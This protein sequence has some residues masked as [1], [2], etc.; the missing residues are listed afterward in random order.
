MILEK[1][2]RFSDA[3]FRRVAKSEAS[4]RICRSEKRSS[5]KVG[6]APSRIYIW[7]LRWQEQGVF[8]CAKKAFFQVFLN[9][10]VSDIG[11][12]L[13]LWGT[14]ELAWYGL[15]VGR[16]DTISLIRILS[17][18][19][20]LH[21][22]RSC[23]SC[24]RKSRILRWFL[25]DFCGLSEDAF[26][27]TRGRR[28][29][30]LWWIFFGLLFGVLGIVTSPM[31]ATVGIASAILLVLLFAVP[32]LSLFLLMFALPFLNLFPHPTLVLIAVVFV[33]GLACLGKLVSG[34]RQV[35][36]G[37]TDG[38]VLWLGVLYALSGAVSYGSPRDGFLRAF[39]LLTG[40]F[41]ARI[42]LFQTKWRRRGV[43]ALS[44]A[45]LICAVIGIVEY[46]T[47]NAP[48]G[49]VDKSRFEDIGGRV[50]GVFNNPNLFAIFLL[51]TTLLPLSVCFKK[52]GTAT[53]WLCFFSFF[54]GSVCLVLTWSRGAWL[55]WIISV[56]LL[57]MLGSRRSFSLLLLG[58]AF[59]VCAIS[60]LP[61]SMIS[62]FQSIGN[63][64]DTSIHYRLN[65]WKGVL[66]MIGS[67]PW[68]IGCGEEAFH[69]VFS[70]YAVSGTE[71]V[72]HPHQML[73]EAIS[74]LGVVGFLFFLLIIWRLL[75]RFLRF[76]YAMPQGRDRGEGIAIFCALAGGMVMGMFDSLWYH[77]GLFWLFWVFCGMCENLR[78]EVTK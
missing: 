11:T 68:G 72:M 56:F 33:C 15:L 40:W 34:K 8:F 61:S 60:F 65:T 10:R 4:K 67:H 7:M 25:F 30:R 45:S 48:L 53:K 70:A 19:V 57:L 46:V 1:L 17:A 49:W 42:L 54:A 73:L 13:V 51:L 2:D 66:R 76:C 24:I 71:G 6:G 74:E 55:G 28:T 52:D 18:S 39:L 9:S 58:G 50:C 29:S 16:F 35:E 26:R 41:L 23:G 44:A 64:A 14:V 47:G 63:F 69:R 22:Q 27:E 12:F 31:I 43:G 20:L 3:I 32:E 38:L 21:S 37:K 59:S 62:R 78:V 5:C 77:S 36:W 75:M